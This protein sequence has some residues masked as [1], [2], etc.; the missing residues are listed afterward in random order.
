MRNLLPLSLLLAACS[1]E[2]GTTVAFKDDVIANTDEPVDT[3][4]VDTEVVDSDPAVDTEVDTDPADTDP[5]DDTGYSGP[6]ADSLSPG[7]LVLT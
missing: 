4:V 3:E 1:V 7:D 6:T 5:A 2:P